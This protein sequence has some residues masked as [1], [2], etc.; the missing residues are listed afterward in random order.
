MPVHTLIPDARTYGL[1]VFIMYTFGGLGVAAQMSS[2]RLNALG[3]GFFEARIFILAFTI[4]WGIAVFGPG[5]V[6]VGAA[7]GDPLGVAL[8]VAVGALV[9]ATSRLADRGILRWIYRRRFHLKSGSVAAVG[10]TVSRTQPA[11]GYKLLKTA[12]DRGF[13][14]NRSR[15]LIRE[16]R[17]ESGRGDRGRYRELPMI[18]AIAMLEEILFRGVVIGACRSTPYPMLEGAGILG[19]VL[20]FAGLHVQ[21]G[22]SHVLSK[23]PLS[24]LATCAVLATN[25]VVPAICAHLLFNMSVWHDRSQIADEV[26]L[27][28]RR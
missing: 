26:P 11:P 25:S 27:T 6:P 10:R 4:F 8:L 2:S 28:S 14:G 1:A 18:M 13:Y 22:S 19:M 9:G 23:L 24:A 7:A 5:V 21:F 15:G 20:L 17:E 3:V 16:I 12:S